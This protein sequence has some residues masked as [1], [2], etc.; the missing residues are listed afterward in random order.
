MTERVGPMYDLIGRN[1]REAR[2]VAALR[3]T[4]LPELI[5]GAIRVKQAEQLVGSAT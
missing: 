1:D 4:L 5:S 2:T 3:D